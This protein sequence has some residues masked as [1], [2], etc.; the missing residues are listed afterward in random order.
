MFCSRWGHR[1]NV[2]HFSAPNFAKKTSPWSVSGGMVRKTMNASALV[3]AL[4]SWDL[5]DQ[6]IRALATAFLFVGNASLFGC[7]S[8]VPSGA[9][10][11][12]ILPDKPGQSASYT[13]E[14]HSQY[15][16]YSEKY[17]GSLHLQQRSSNAVIVSGRNVRITEDAF[18]NPGVRQIRRFSNTFTAHR[19]GVDGALDVPSTELG[20]A[21]QAFDYNSLIA[22]LP[23]HA[24]RA[25]PATHQWTTTTTCWVS[26]TV[27]A[28]IPVTVSLERK[29]DAENLTALGRGRV[30]LSA[31][32]HAVIAD[33]SIA[34]TAV[35]A[36]GT[37]TRGAMHARET[38]E[39][40]GLPAGGGSYVWTVKVENQNRE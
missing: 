13:F 4:E 11:L 26:D 39:R 7:T 10:V 18:S 1:R 40:N 27:S 32:R 34:M 33:M 6:L 25:D 12:T 28:A 36:H 20:V 19:A 30:S 16:G 29:T 22:L 15:G 8:N 24:S 31:G 21:D 23:Q 14:F 5:M 3:D 2:S 9:A 38:Y 17:S 35:F 37:L